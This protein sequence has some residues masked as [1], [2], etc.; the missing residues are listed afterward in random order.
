M[1]EAVHKTGN[2]VLIDT[3]AQK[4]ALRLGVA[5]EAVRAEFKKNS[6]PPAVP[7][8]SEEESFEDAAPETEAAPPSPLELHLLKLLLLHDELVATA[9]LNLEANWISH[10]QI[11]QLVDLRLAAQEHET[12]HSLTE[13]LD[14]C[15]SSEQRSLITEAVA[16]DRKIPNP[17]IQLADMTLKLRN[18]FLDRQIG[19]LTQKISQPGLADDERVALLRE[20]LKLKEQKRSPLAPLEK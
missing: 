10:P 15:E 4:T 6:A 3:Y 1:A 5:A 12:W 19:A 9:A 7:R 16:A 8:A 13:F 2:G 11:R 20:Q 14:N 18:Q 17:E